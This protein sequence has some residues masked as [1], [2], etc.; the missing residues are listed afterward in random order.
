MRKEDV[1]ETLDYEKFRR[2]P[3]GLNRELDFRHT[4][5]M[6]QSV[7]LHGNNRLV[8]IVKTDVI[9][10]V[11]REYI[12]DGQHLFEALVVL[13]KHIVY[14]HVIVGT[15]EQL[16]KLLTDMNNTSKPWT[17]MNYI[18]AWAE[19]NDDYKHL[20]RSVV[21]YGIK[22]QG[23]AMVAMNLPARATI[24]HMIKLGRYHVVDRTRFRT[25]MNHVIDLLSI[26]ELGTSNAGYLPNR[27]IA[28]FIR[29][30]GSTSSYNHFIIKQRLIDNVD[31]IRGVYAAVNELETILEERIFYVE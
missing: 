1:L 10:G 22:P 2:L 19:L 20:Q 17:L 29:H 14:K 5:V 25:M 13:G 6:R 12:A 23:V 9:D 30:Y 7:S 24:A 15:K 3:H 18:D 16:V 21:R 28:A 4:A 27:L 31:L 8:I 11:M 26:P